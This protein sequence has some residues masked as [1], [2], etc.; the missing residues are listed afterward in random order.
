[1]D[2]TLELYPPGTLSDLFDRKYSAVPVKKNGFDPFG[3]PH[4]KQ[5]CAHVE[6]TEQWGVVR[7]MN[8]AIQAQSGWLC[9]KHNLLLDVRKKQENRPT[10]REMVT[11]LVGYDA[12]MIK[13][14][15]RVEVPGCPFS[16]LKVTYHE[17]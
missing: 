2:V 12:V 1:M 10:E 14:G 15:K 13:R 16:R 4:V 3:L 9:A 7:C 17:R 8:N 11:A 6:Q 5:Q